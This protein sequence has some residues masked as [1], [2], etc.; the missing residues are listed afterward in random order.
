MA[1]VPGSLG[2]EHRQH[3]LQQVVYGGGGASQVVGSPS[4]REGEAAASGHCAGAVRAEQPLL[5]GKQSLE[6]GGDIGRVSAETRLRGSAVFVADLFVVVVTILLKVVIGPRAL[7]AG[8][9]P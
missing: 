1:R 8:G 3:R 6:G 4:P 5:V 2:A 9:N 7:C